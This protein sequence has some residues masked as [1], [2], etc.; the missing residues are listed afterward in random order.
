MQSG[1]WSLDTSEPFVSHGTR[2]AA[3][4]GAPMAE[5]MDGRADLN[6]WRGFDR[7]AIPGHFGNPFL[8]FVGACYRLKDTLQ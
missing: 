3:L 4:M 7:P 1:S 8:S 5:I 6:S 2:M